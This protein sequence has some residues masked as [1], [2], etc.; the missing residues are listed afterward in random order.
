M[1]WMKLNSLL[2]EGAMLNLWIRQDTF[3]SNIKV[4]KAELKRKS[5]GN[6]VKVKRNSFLIVKPE[7]QL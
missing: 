2:V 7:Q 3:T 4:A 1:E 6:V 5:G